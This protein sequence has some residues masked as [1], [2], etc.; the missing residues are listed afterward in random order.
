MKKMDRH[1][2]K[3]LYNKCY[4]II[5]FK[6]KYNSFLNNSASNRK[7]YNYKVINLCFLNTHGSTYYKYKS[8]WFIFNKNFKRM[9]A[10][11]TFLN[12]NKTSIVKILSVYYN[13]NGKVFTHWNII[14]KNTLLIVKKNE[15]DD[16]HDKGQLFYSLVTNDP[17]KDLSINCIILDI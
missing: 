4:S 15:N 11:A 16:D 9:F 14:T 10:N 7:K 8:N 1:V 5:E 17:E 2:K 12:I 3:K 6:N 13:P